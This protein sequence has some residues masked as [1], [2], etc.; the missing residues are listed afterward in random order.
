MLGLKVVRGDSPL[1][2][3][4]K[5]LF[6]GLPSSKVETAFVRSVRNAYPDETNG[7][8]DMKQLI[9]IIALLAVTSAHASHVGASRGNHGP[10]GLGPAGGQAAAGQASKASSS[11]N[12]SSSGGA[13]QSG[14]NGSVVLGYCDVA[15]YSIC[16]KE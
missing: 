7:E 12:A 10:A 13:R 16:Y 15:H 3:Q 9:T 14:G 1:C 11:A 5:S 8:P 6:A 2:G 4:R